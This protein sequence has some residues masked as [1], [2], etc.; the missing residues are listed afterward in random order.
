MSP[1]QNTLRAF[2]TLRMLN[3]AYR[4]SFFVGFWSWVTGHPLPQIVYTD[5]AGQGWTAHPDQHEAWAPD[6][7]QHETW[8]RE[9]R[10]LLWRYLNDHT[11]AGTVNLK[12]VGLSASPRSYPVGW[13]LPMGQELAHACR[14]LGF[15]QLAACAY[16]GL[17][18]TPVYNAIIQAISKEAEG[19]VS[20]CAMSD[21]IEDIQ[22]ET[23][24]TLYPGAYLG[25]PLPSN[26][27]RAPLAPLV[28]S[29][30]PIH[31]EHLTARKR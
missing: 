23:N 5:D 21:D 8:K 31:F 26:R 18:S 17:D 14:R 11:K 7:G 28:L 19:R 4:R 12:D 29:T 13:L 24:R 15:S 10:I 20:R 27:V 25:E 22:D 3:S 1:L 30:D 6:Q 9:M 2:F 16:P